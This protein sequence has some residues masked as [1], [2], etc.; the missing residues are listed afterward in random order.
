MVN[1]E[2]KG[3]NYS[4]EGKK[5]SSTSLISATYFQA[6]NTKSLFFINM[7]CIIRSKMF[8]YINFHFSH[9]DINNSLFPWQPLFTNS[10]TIKLQFFFTV[11]HYLFNKN[12]EKHT[13]F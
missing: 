8:F 9:L 13:H 5:T 11:N 2:V 3:E 1:M 10:D 6:F 12:A 7:T 4:E